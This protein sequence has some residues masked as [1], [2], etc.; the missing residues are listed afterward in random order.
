[1]PKGQYK[2]AA[3]KVVNDSPE[4]LPLQQPRKYRVEV[5]NQFD[6]PLVVFLDVRAHNQAEAIQKVKAVGLKFAAEIA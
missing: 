2:R 5:T 6:E 4:P 3:R 1:M